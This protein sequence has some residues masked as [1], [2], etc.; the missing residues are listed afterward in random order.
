MSDLYSGEQVNEII[1]QFIDTRD[2]L[3]EK[4]LKFANIIDNDFENGFGTFLFKRIT[5]DE[6]KDNG[7]ILDYFDE[8]EDEI[9]NLLDEKRS[10]Y[11]IAERAKKY[12]E[13]SNKLSDFYDKVFDYYEQYNLGE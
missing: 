6:I 10:I 5:M 7:K 8:I 4:H 13:L 2:S 1:K 12:I 3:S 11:K 9:D